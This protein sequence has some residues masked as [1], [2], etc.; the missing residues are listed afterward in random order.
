MSSARGV[1]RVSG[2]SAEDFAAA[3]WAKILDLHVRET[4]SRPEDERE[5]ATEHTRSMEQF[6]DEWSEDGPLWL[7]WCVHR[8]FLAGVSWA[9]KQS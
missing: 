1:Q 7:G 8:A 3:P 9:R 2:H 5:A 4:L 6:A